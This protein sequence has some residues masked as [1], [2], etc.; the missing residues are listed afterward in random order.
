M[1]MAV[2]NLRL[3][4]G[5]TGITWADAEAEA[6]I[7]CIAGLGF[8]YIEVF[9]WVLKTF[10]DQGKDDVCAKYGIPLISSYFSCDIVSPEKR[11]AEIEK[12]S[13]WGDIVAGMGGQ[14]ATFGGNGVD[15]RAFQFADHKAYAVNF[16]NEAAKILDSKGLRLSFH[17]HTGTP[18]ETKDEI[19][20]FMDSVDTRYVGFA[21]DIGQIQ[22]GGSD[23]MRFVR[24]YLSVLSLVHFKDFSGSVRFDENGKEVDTTGF[25]CYTPLG[26]GVV[27]LSGILEYLERSTFDGPV[28]IE[29]D[30]GRDMPSTA[31]E[32][33]GV[34][35]AYMEKLGYSF[36]SR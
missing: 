21:P 30:R 35:K 32:A 27:D 34:N 1:Y 29:L 8:H 24:D 10:H 7:R 5:H 12:L 26:R 16:V 25:A 4:I 31:E 33:V 2:T 23:P 3:K 28:M 17:P 6:G 36:V 22:K 19:I 9:A 20:S 11:D 14:Y 13:E 18:V 15:R